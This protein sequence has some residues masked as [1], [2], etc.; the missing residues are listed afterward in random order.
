LSNFVILIAQRQKFGTYRPIRL[1][2]LKITAPHPNTIFNE[3]YSLDVD[4]LTSRLNQS[5]VVATALIQ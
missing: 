4:T 1:P 2:A 5:L 3:L